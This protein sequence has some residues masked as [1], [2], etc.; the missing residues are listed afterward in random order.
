M[1]I[2]APIS[3]SRPTI[4]LLISSV[5]GF[6]K[7]P[8][9]GVVDAARARGANVVCFSGSVIG[10]LGADRRQHELFRPNNILF[11]LVDANRIDGLVVWSSAIDGVVGGEGMQQFCERYRPLPL[12]CVE[13]ALT[14]FPSLLMDDYAGIAA[15]MHHFI[16]VH[17]YRRIAFISGAKNHAGARERYR[18]YAEALT[19]HGLPLDPALVTPPTSYWNDEECAANVAQWFDASRP[20][21]DAIMGVNDAYTFVAQEILAARG[22]R[23]PDDVGAAGFDAQPEGA[24]M[25]VPLTTVRPPFYELGWKAAEMVLDMLA[26]QPVDDRITLPTQLLVRQSC[27]CFVSS[28]VQSISTARCDAALHGEPSVGDIAQVVAKN[29]LTVPAESANQLLVDIISDAAGRSQ[30]RFLSTLNALLRQASAAGNLAG[31]HHVVSTLRAYLLAGQG[32][33][34]LMRATEDLWQQARLLIGE[35]EQREA[36]SQSWQSQQQW[37]AF[38]R[39]GRSLITTFDVAELMDVVARELPQLG[40][41][42]CYVALYENPHEEIERARLILAYDEH[43]RVELPPDGLPFPARQLLPDVLWRPDLLYNLIVEALHFNDQQLG[44]VFFEADSREDW[45]YEAL[46]SELSSSLK[47]SLLVKQLEQARATAEEA[48]TFKSNF[49]ANMSHELRTPLNAILNFTRFM[50]KERYGT[51]T[52]RQIELQQRIFVNA[53]HLLGLINDILDLSKIESGRMDLLLEMTDLGPLLHGVMATA[54]GLTKDKGLVLS[55]DADDDLP[56]IWIDKTR[57][58][59]VL[60]N[61]LSNAAKF[62]ELG[63]ITLRATLHQQHIEL[64]VQDTGIGIAPEHQ[65]L[66]F[67]EFRQVQNGLTRHYQGTGLGLAISRRLVEMHGGRMWLESATGRGSTFYFTL[68]LNSAIV[69]D[70]YTEGAQE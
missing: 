59:Q 64:S 3:K 35:A 37:G 57:V 36:L 54:A 31:W 11:D 30:G 60:L 20:N 70:A 52:E 17:G 16:E 38:R 53:D 43:G 29:A 28:A 4:G 58:R 12:V 61:L 22:I 15:A 25:N 47:G 42:R 51:L 8:W 49:V 66:V 14:G 67:E 6:W 27:G 26:G 63:S 5:T 41:R 19:R 65:S 23:V 50:G 24:Y 13:R 69:A 39:L 34:A 1:S 10:N 2:Q 40:M 44:F 7:W 48:S 55:L 45:V 18:A 32:D 68:P 9:L 56:H 62:T 21:F 46:R 33:P